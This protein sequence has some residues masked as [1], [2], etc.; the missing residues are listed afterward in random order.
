V[1]DTTRLTVAHNC[2]STRAICYI[3]LPDFRPGQAEPRLTLRAQ[4][5]G[6][7]NCKLDLTSLQKDDSMLTFEQAPSQGSAAIL[8]KLTV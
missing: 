7:R 4:T 2:F 1:A 6:M 8:E 5:L 3:L